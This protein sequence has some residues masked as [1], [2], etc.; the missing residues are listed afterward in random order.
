MQKAQFENARNSG[1]R[2]LP[3]RFCHLARDWLKRCVF[4]IMS[5]I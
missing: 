1:D 4:F 3:P 2:H 5:H